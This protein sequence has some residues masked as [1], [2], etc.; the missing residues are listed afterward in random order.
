MHGEFDS[1]PRFSSS[2][3]LCQNDCQSGRKLSLIAKR[4]VREGF[5]PSVHKSTGKRNF[6]LNTLSRNCVEISLDC[7]RLEPVRWIAAL[8]ISF[9]FADCRHATVRTMSTE[10]LVERIFRILGHVFKLGIAQASPMKCSGAC[11]GRFAFFPRVSR[12]AVEQ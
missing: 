3:A 2:A 8:I 11:S 12:R 9:R 5:E 4:T 6:N 7:F 1:E 10:A